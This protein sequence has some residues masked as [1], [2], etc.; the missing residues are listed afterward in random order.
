MQTT[1]TYRVLQRSFINNTIFEPGETVEFAG[2][3]GENL[4]LV[5]EQDDEQPVPRGRRKA[6]EH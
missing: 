6:P 1:K 3:T 2:E 4:E 5:D